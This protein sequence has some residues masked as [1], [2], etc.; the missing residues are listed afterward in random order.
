[1]SART[2]P[3]R[4]CHVITGLETGGAER[5]LHK[6]ATRLDP[7]RFHTVVVSLRERAAMA[8]PLERAGAEVHAAGLSLARPS[9]RA[10]ARVGAM[11][12]QARPHVVHGWMYHGNIAASLAR[13]ARFTRAPVL[14]NV[15]ASIDGFATM[16]PATVAAVKLGARLSRHPRRIVY[17]SR[18]GARQHEAIGYASG[19]ATVIPNGFDCDA[20]A[21]QPAVGA[22]VRA[23][24]GIP[25]DAIVLGQ[26]ARY[27]PMKN[28][29]GLVHA[30]AALRAGRDVHLLMAGRGVDARNERLAALVREL[31]LSD[32][33]HLVGE[34]G[35]VPA[36]M[37]ALDVL[38]SPSN[39]LE[40]FPN[41]VGEAM[42]SAVPCVVTDVGDAAWIVDD[43]G[44]V[45]PPWQ[46][47]ALAD[48]LR[49]MVAL[50]AERRA[51]LGAAARERV[52]A[53]FS[54]ETVT[55]AYEELYLASADACT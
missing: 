55:A 52:R 12:R 17:N 48:A 44:M 29:E 39:C 45:V 27:D 54:L 37:A 5:M 21:P 11:V 16:K 20:Y 51:A 15:R 32:R 41:A 9:P 28:Q 4:V 23:E 36:L 53:H 18:E 14:W 24:L 38:V 35:D 3:L 33:V 2:T 42:A 46:P 40:G 13:M 10:L 7:E 30:A 1:M 19:R 26:V 50:P 31:G 6:L 22:R 47:E 49:V 43:T 34:R 8:E 25:H